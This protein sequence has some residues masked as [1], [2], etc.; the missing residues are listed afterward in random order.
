LAPRPKGFHPR[1]VVLDCAA[2]RASGGYGTGP[3]CV[4]SFSSRA[5]NVKGLDLFLIF[6]YIAVLFVYILLK[7]PKSIG[8]EDGSFN[9]ACVRACVLL[10]KVRIGV[11]VRP[12]RI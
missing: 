4:F 12:G 11:G 6:F 2:T 9:F 3:D 5:I 7:K 10:A 8:W 1:Q